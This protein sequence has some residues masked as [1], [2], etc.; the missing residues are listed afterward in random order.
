MAVRCG[1]RVTRQIPQAKRAIGGLVIGFYGMIALTGRGRI[2]AKDT[3]QHR[4]PM[5]CIVVLRVVA[6]VVSGAWMD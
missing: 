1:L 6:V 4:G 5:R 2:G 3:R